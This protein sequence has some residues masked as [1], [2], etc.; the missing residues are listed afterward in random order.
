MLNQNVDILD[1]KRFVTIDMSAASG[2]GEAE[3]TK[4]PANGGG[5]DYDN[6]EWG[7]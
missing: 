7:L 1:F 4:Q 2:N 6:V 5:S 3:P